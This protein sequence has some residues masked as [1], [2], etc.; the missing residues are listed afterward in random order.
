MEDLKSTFFTAILQTWF[1]LRKQKLENELF[2]RSMYTVKD[3]K[4]QK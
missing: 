4:N 2:K 1:H 3:A